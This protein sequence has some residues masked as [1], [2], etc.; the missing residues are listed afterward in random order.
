M[1]GG[2]QIGQGGDRAEGVL[3]ERFPLHQPAAVGN[4]Q[5]EGIRHHLPG[6]HRIRQPV[7]GTAAAVATPV[8]LIRGLL[9]DVPGQTGH[10]PRPEPGDMGV[11]VHTAPG[12]ADQLRRQPVPG[13]H[14]V[15]VEPA[16]SV[17]VLQHFQVADIPNADVKNY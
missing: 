17:P 11:S 10:I 9:C 3:T 16:V 14:P 13:Q 12:V 8:D 7:G 15:E 5:P 6:H 1:S 2:R 4:G